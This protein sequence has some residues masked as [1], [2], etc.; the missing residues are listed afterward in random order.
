MG[1]AASSDGGAP[2][3]PTE[4]RLLALSLEGGLPDTAALFLAKNPALAFH[5]D[6]RGNTP[7]HAV[8]RCGSGAGALPAAQLLL[9]TLRSSAASN[10]CAGDPGRVV[11]PRA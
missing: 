11:R 2:G 8:A 4:G 7:M 10:T 5:V 9:S 1:Q 6:A 3:D